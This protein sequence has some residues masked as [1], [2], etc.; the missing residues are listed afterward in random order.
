MVRMAVRPTSPAQ[1]ARELG[2][3]ASLVSYHAKA[4]EKRGLV[5]KVDERPIRGAIEHFYRAVRL[6]Q[7]DQT[8]YDDLTPQE[9]QTWL[10]TVFGLISAD[11]MYSIE[12]GVLPDQDDCEIARTSMKVD[13]QG[14]QDLRA[15]YIDVQERVM[16]I[17]AEAETRLAIEDSA[18]RSILSFNALFEMPPAK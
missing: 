3:E 10:E 5:E 9:R 16:A 8:E 6:V 7:V 12:A 13:E 14:W 1:V 17:K 2:I 4:L 15:A 18:P 11:A